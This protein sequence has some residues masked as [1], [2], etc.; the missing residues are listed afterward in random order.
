MGEVLVGVPGL[1]GD[2]NEFDGDWDRLEYVAW[3]VLKRAVNVRK[4]KLEYIVSC[5]WF[6]LFGCGIDGKEN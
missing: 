6:L 3:F 1:F 4:N 2:R 5:N